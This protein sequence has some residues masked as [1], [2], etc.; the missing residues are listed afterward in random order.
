VCN[1]IVVNKRTHSRT[2]NDV[3]IG[4]G[5]EWGNPFIIGKDGSRSDVIA[6]YRDYMED[7]LHDDKEKVQRLLALNGK[8]LVCYC[9]PQA[10]HGDV[11]VRLIRIIKRLNN[12]HTHTG[13]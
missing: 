12:S 1:T 2:A 7:M 9:K 4:R 3:Y 10:C 8:T 5:S 11:L 13:D 6:E